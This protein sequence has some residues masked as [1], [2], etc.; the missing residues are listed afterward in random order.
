MNFDQPIL[1][2]EEIDDLIQEVRAKTGKRWKVADCSYKQETW[3]G[4]RTEKV[5]R[6]R[7]Y[8]PISNTEFLVV[9][10][11]LN[12]NLDGY[13][14]KREVVIGFLLGLLSREYVQ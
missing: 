4:F 3:F 1:D 5:T 13:D 14:V 2:D 12:E 6:Y 10:F 9:K 8:A 7:V 11:R